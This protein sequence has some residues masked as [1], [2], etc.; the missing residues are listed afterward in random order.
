MILPTGLPPF[1]RIGQLA[2]ALGEPTHTLRHWEDYFSVRADRSK[3]GQRVYRATHVAKL[4]AIQDL[5]R[6]QK[7][8][9]EGARIQLRNAAKGVRE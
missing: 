9:L 6:R 8:T 1:C 5:V 3:S 7:F 2:K 4:V